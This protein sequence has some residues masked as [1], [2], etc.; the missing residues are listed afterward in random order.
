MNETASKKKRVI[1]FF[2][3]DKP[4]PYLVILS[5]LVTMALVWVGNP[6]LPLEPLASVGWAWHHIPEI[7]GFLFFGIYLA[8][9]GYLSTE[10]LNYLDSTT[11]ILVAVVCLSYAAVIS[12]NEM[13]RVVL[14]IVFI[15]SFSGYFAA[16][17]RSI[18]RNKKFAQ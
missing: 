9:L 6:V 15:P 2:A 14:V 18:R 12:Y 8:N 16:R 4:W 17:F 7:F 3:L 11:L 10:N 1:R 13:F 5:Y